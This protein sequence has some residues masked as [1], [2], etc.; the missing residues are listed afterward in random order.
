M[1][2]PADFPHAIAAWC[3]A[4]VEDWRQLWLGPKCRFLAAARQIACDFDRDELAELEKLRQLSPDQ[5]L[6]RAQ[7]LC[8]QSKSRTPAEQ[9]AW[10]RCA[11]LTPGLLAAVDAARAIRGW[12]TDEELPSP[13]AEAANRCAEAYDQAWPIRG[14]PVACSQSHF[15][16]PPLTASP[17]IVAALNRLAACRTSPHF[18]TTTWLIL[19]RLLT[20]LLG[21]D[22]PRSRFETQATMLLYDEN[23][24]GGIPGPLDVRTA[25]E[26]QTG[27]YLDPVAMGGAAIDDNMAD[28]LRLAWRITRSELSRRIGTPLFRPL[29]IRLSPGLTCFGVVLHRPGRI[30]RRTD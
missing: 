30:G 26:G 29:A 25:E 7:A 10:V 14:E 21:Y 20:Y 11:W 18:H 17:S 8:P 3:R 13:F 5:Q 24:R 9:T 15:H 27:C 6:Q 4:H 16:A 12:R 23:G 28:S 22:D 1:K 19:R 2:A